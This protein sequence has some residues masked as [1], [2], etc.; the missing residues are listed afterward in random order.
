MGMRESAS[1]RIAASPEPVFSLVTDPPRLPSWNQAIADV[2]E[3]PEHLKS[4]TVCKVRLHAL[5]Q[6]WLSKS[7]VSTLDPVAGRIAY[8]SQTDMTTL[9]RRLARRARSRRSKVTVTVE[10]N[11]TTFRRKYL[12]VRIRHFALRKEIGNSLNALGA[13]LS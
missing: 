3:A 9:V 6:S 8:R 11:P 12:L 2:V 7:P 10:L 5:G 13:A 1:A 4:G